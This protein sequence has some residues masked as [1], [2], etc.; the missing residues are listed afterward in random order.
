M[1]VYFL[2]SGNK[3]AIKIGLA[4][5][6]QKRMEVLQAGNAFELKLLA[7]IPCKSRKEAEWIEER[8][9]KRFHKQRIR[10]EWFQGN[11]EIKRIRDEFEEVNTHIS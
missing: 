7:V 6:V 5:N 9:H 4:R 3:G 2:R 11:I 10:G 8:L 1:F